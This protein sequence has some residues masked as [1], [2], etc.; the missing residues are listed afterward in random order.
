MKRMNTKNFSKQ[1]ADY[2]D[3]VDFIFIK[4][5][6]CENLRNLRMVFSLRNRN[7]SSS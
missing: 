5:F 6:I 1:S 3:D 2:A 4:E 7:P